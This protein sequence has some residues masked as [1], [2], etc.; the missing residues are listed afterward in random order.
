MDRER[1][2]E[3]WHETR[4]NRGSERESWGKGEGNKGRRR[5]ERIREGGGGLT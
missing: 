5:K 2:R 4:V 3:G 1:E